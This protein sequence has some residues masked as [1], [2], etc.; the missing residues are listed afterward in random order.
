MINFN[1]EILPNAQAKLHV[2]N[3][4]FA[5]GDAVFETIRVNGN[6]I[7]FWEDHYFRLMASMRILR[8]RI[9]MNFTLEYLE[10]QVLDTVA[11]H[12]ISKS[13]SVRVKLS[14]FRDSEGLYTPQKN[15]IGFFISIA[16]IDAPFYSLNKIDT[17]PYEVEL[18]KDHLVAKDI[19]ST[20]K[21]NNRVL[22]VLAG[23][24]AKENGFA[25]MLLLNT[26]KKVIEATN[27]NVFLIKGNTIKTPPVSDGCI[28]GILKKQILRILK[29]NTAFEVKE[30]SISAFELQKADELF[31]TNVISGITSVSKYRK[32]QYSSD[33]SKK[34]LNLLNMD[35][36]LKK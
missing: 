15:N 9:P 5:Y 20:L 31:V 18:F 12:G 14:V 28:S 21:T 25:N 8:M 33:V 19:L 13:Q 16:K 1:G 11:S 34:I 35:I 26:D 36:R 32:K 3:R 7:L 6:V 10:K 2:F 24:F 30:T 17:T 22:N 4:G 27:G 23:I 29:N